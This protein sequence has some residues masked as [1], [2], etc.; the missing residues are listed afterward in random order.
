[1][2]K[3]VIFDFFGVFC[4]DITFAWFIKNY[5]DSPKELSRLQEICDLSDQGKLNKYDFYNELSIITGLNKDEVI[6]G[7]EAEVLIDQNVVG[8]VKTLR[9]NGILIACLSN[10]THEW[11]LDIINRHG[12]S[13]LF[14]HIILSADIKMSKP[15]PEIYKY[16]LNQLGVDA[17]QALFI[18]DRLVNTVAAEKC[19]II[20]HTFTDSKHLID[21]CR[22]QNIQKD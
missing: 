18:D 1:M 15:S 12:L 22:K 4:P 11:T 16:T 5:S 8:L 21:F 10:G 6:A 7:V 17:A 19:G 2:I 20:S 14:D 3:A 9:S 13:Y